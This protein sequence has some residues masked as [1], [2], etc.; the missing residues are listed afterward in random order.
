MID[1]LR[2]LKKKAAYPR[3]LLKLFLKAL[4]HKRVIVHIGNYS[5]S[6]VAHGNVGD[7]VL[8]KELEKLIENISGSNYYWIPRSIIF[9]EINRLEVW[10]Y[11]HFT[12]GI[13]VGG[14]G[15][16]MVDTG[17]NPNSGWQFNIKVEN[18]KRIRV[19][20]A[21]MAIG[22]N[23]FR[24][25]PD[26]IDVF[27]EHI[28]ICISNSK[29]F[30]LRNWGSIRALMPYVD[31]ENKAK[32]MF[33]PCPT[34][35]LTLYEDL[36]VVKKD[37]EIGICLAFDRYENRFGTIFDQ[38]FDNLILFAHRFESEGYKITFYAHT[39]TDLNHP[40]CVKFEKEGY[41]V[42]TI[43]G[44]KFSDVFEWYMRKKL[45]VGMRGH[46]LMIP[47][48]VGTPVVSLTTQ[49]KQKWFMEITGH[50]ERSIEVQ[51]TQLLSKLYAEVDNILSNYDN[52]ANEIL[53]RQKEFYEISKNNIGKYAM[54]G[55]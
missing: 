23:T 53:K 15:L 22:Y 51:D 20:M 28:N 35:M 26:F 48:G 6:E 43:S 46:S 50:N 19:P 30:G 24:G 7:P 27:R 33:Q 5:H 49:N 1:K 13:L 4:F 12:S 54:G 41:V 38:L 42:E 32:V 18:L 11:N 17:K 2:K 37:K 34:T 55:G 47:W 25:Q 29:F 40:N 44:L 16:L 31:N 14:H 9:H 52:E 8:F 45:I 36:P 10:I 39:L 21:F 3:M